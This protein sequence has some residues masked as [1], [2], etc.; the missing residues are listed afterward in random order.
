MFAEELDPPACFSIMDLSLSVLARVTCSVRYHVRASGETTRVLKRNRER[1]PL[2]SLVTND[3][4]RYGC[5][6]ALIEYTRAVH[7][8]WWCGFRHSWSK[9]AGKV[10]EGHA[11]HVLLAHL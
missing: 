5:F 1:P 8:P 3:Y 7:T 4:F 11:F 10:R 2:F 9:A 6:R